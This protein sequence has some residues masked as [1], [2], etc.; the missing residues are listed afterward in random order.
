M[1]RVDIRRSHGLSSAQAHAVIDRI[2]ARMREKFQVKTQ[3][4][5]KDTLSFQRLGIDGKIVIEANEIHVSA[6]LGML[7]S[8][9]KTMIEQEI[10]RHLDEHFT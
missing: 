10:R 2:A 1:P 8:P 7:L 5:C 6:R 9:L 4:Q 3:W